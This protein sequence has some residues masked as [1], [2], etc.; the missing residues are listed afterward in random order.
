M[1]QQEKAL[2]QRADRILVS[3]EKLMEV[4]QERYGA[5][6]LSKITLVRNGYN[7]SVLNTPAAPSSSDGAYTLSYFGTI[8]SW[9]NFDYVVRSLEDFPKLSY[10]LMGPAEVEIPAHP[11]L[12]YIGT[13]EHSK[14][15]EATKDAQCLIMPFL[16]NEIIDAVDPV[17]LYEYINFNKN[18][19]CIRYPEIQRF[20]PFVHFYTDYESYCRQLQ[21]LMDSTGVKYT[22]AQRQDFLSSN[23]WESRVAQIEKLL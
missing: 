18:I 11:R 2:V 19:L 4:L 23:N 12:R 7:G 14:L 5:E 8:S 15:P 22:C 1:Q 10:L 13:V 9:F 3:S 17:K 20:E 6:N 21:L 16:R